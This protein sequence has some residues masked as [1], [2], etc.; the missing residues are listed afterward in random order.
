MTTRLVLLVVLAVPSTYAAEMNVLSA[1]EAAAG[2]QLLFDGQSTEGWRNYQASTTSPGWRVVDGTLAR[3]DEAGDLVTVAQYGD[4]EL[5]LEWRLET[6]GNSGLF[7]RAGE[8]D[9]YIF[10]SAP[11]VQM[12]DDANHRDGQSPLTSAGS[13]Y[14]LH[15]VQ[16][17][18]TLAAGHW[19]RV[20]VLVDD[21]L[22]V[23]WLNG[24]EVVRYELG[25][26]DWRQRVQDS[27]FAAWPNYGKLRRGHIGLQDHGDPVAFRNIKI[28]IL[29]DGE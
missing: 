12:L 29:A 28:R 11:E 20:R 19:N 6:G 16:P 18:I 15:P 22:V 17:G 14:G 13:N 5:Q 8:D 27:K 2:W 9:P 10:M 3:V 26:A 4:F 21:D 7:I 1:E 25:S 24:Q 23:Q